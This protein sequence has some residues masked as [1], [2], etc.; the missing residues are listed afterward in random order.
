[1]TRLIDRIGLRQ[2]I[3]D[4]AASGRT[5]LGTCAGLIMLAREVEED[6]ARHG[7]EPLGLLDVVVR[8]NGF[9]RQ[10]DSFEDEVTHADGTTSPGVF[11]RAPRILS[12]GEGV[13][14]VARWKDEPVAVRG[15]N[16]IGLT[17]H[18]EASNDLRS[19]RGVQDPFQL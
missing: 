9:G 4:F 2:P 1:M 6:R 7:V 10:I 5:I 8:R 17:Y 18:P 19:V 3:L 11:I 13:E 14:V 15:G 16:I 12:V